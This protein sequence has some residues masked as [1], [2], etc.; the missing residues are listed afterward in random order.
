MLPVL[1][2]CDLPEG[3]IKAKIGPIQYLSWRSP[4][5]T[6]RLISGIHKAISPQRRRRL[7]RAAVAA[8]FAL[9]VATLFLYISR[10]LA[11]LEDARSDET[12]AAGAYRRLN[13]ANALGIPRL[14]LR[15]DRDPRL[16]AQRYFE[17]RAQA[18]DHQAEALFDAGEHEQLRDKVDEA[19]MLSA[20]AAI[21]R[22]GVPSGRAQ[23]VYAAQRYDRL[24]KTIREPGEVPGVG[25]AVRTGPAHW[26]IASGN[27]IWTCAVPLDDRPCQLTKQSVLSFVT[28]SAF[29]S[30]DEVQLV[31]SSSGRATRLRLA[32]KSTDEQRQTGATDLAMDDGEIATA[33]EA[34]P[35]VIIDRA[36][37]AQERSPNFGE[38]AAVR[39]GPCSDCVALLDRKGNVVVWHRANNRSGVVG[40]RPAL[41]IAATK[42]GRL[43]IIRDNG[44]LELYG[45]ELLFSPGPEVDFR[46]ASAMALSIDGRNVAVVNDGAINV[47]SEEKELI[48]GELK[49]TAVAAAF[50]DN[51]TLVTRTPRDVRIWRLGSRKREELTPIELWTKWR[52]QLG[53]FDLHHAPVGFGWDP[54]ARDVRRY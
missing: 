47:I 21:K 30:D 10:Q 48:T 29:K 19:L 36:D 3:E 22:G 1:V 43:A 38:I 23:T 37:G 5:D 54:A 28:A 52:K 8:G 15:G 24:I 32:D 9:A 6:P 39:F 51:G 16:M 17:Q 20:L 44:R 53:L 13:A 4:E 18:L 31:E 46:A 25:L 45:P 2:N 12:R 33:F 26:R 41:A 42:S 14:W 40:K 34:D 50:A 49:P 7:I 11:V 35:S 27:H